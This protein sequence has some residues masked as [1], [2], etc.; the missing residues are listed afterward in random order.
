MSKAIKP[1][2]SYSIPSFR[3]GDYS[4]VKGQLD[5]LAALGFKWVTFTPTYEVKE[6]TR[7]V[8]GD[9]NDVFNPFVIAWRA[10]F[11][12]PTRK[13]KYLELDHEQ[14]P[15][16]ELKA[17]VLAAVEKGFNVKIEPHLDWAATLASKSEDKWRMT[18]Y[19]DPNNANTLYY[20][21]EE[22][23]IGPIIDLIRDAEK[24]TRPSGAGKACYAL[25]LGS[26][27]DVSLYTFTSGWESLKKYSQKRRE[28]LGL[29]EPRRFSIGHKLNYDVFQPRGAVRRYMPAVRKDWGAP[30]LSAKDWV[31]L[32]Q[33]VMGY[34]RNLDYASFS[35]YPPL[36]HK[37]PK[38]FDWTK[39]S[40]K[41]AIDTVAKAFKEASKSL[42]DKV[43]KS[44][45]LDIG[46]FGLGSSDLSQPYGDNPEDF[47]TPDGTGF[48][49]NEK[50]HA[51]RRL[52]IKAMAKF[53]A[54]N[55]SYF[56]AVGKTECC[57]YLPIT[58]WTVKHYDFLGLWDYDVSVGPKNDEGVQAV[59]KHKLFVDKKLIAY[60]KLCNK[61]TYPP[62]TD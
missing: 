38:G 12:Q 60:L 22:K 35:F 33:G 43:G 56:E 47:V 62:E 51:T 17:A 14:T 55:R 7:T 59:A 18:M 50:A 37:V 34:V 31:H 3:S 11:G 44:V 23:L 40:D 39:D 46:E 15:L 9:L 52:W 57:N 42:R 20:G 30:E 45:P 48:K 6:V 1:P 10:I 49:K 27:L 21:Y 61:R 8:K 4:G 29:D 36:D 28:D 53:M 13:I 26:E 54:D 25:T 2:A 32:E 41:R 58:F 19:F 5:K 16:A 24:V